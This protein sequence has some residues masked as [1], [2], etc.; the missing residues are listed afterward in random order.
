MKYYFAIWLICLF[1]NTIAADAQPAARSSIILSPDDSLYNDFFYR[2]EYMAGERLNMLF[3][4]LGIQNTIDGKPFDFD[5]IT[6]PTVIMIGYA[7]CAPCRA[8]L[9]LLITFANDPS[10]AHTD[11]IYLTY[12]N[13]PYIRKELGNLLPGRL[14]IFSVSKDF[15]LGSNML[16]AAFPTVYFLDRRGVVRRFTHGGMTGDEAAKAVRYKWCNYLK[17]ITAN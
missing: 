8:Q 12:D 2:E 3:P 7:D 15:I 11:F 14:N 5:H 17:L 1:C 6:R 9:P 16:A 4:S 13:V 10:Y